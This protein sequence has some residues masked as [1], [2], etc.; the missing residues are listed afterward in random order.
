MNDYDEWVAFTVDLEK[1]DVKGGSYI[2]YELKP[3]H[4]NLPI[5]HFDSKVKSPWWKIW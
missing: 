1:R 5:V 3:M 2:K 4:Q